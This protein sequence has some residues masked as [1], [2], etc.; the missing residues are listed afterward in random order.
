[1]TDTV[2][3][4]L[5]I[6]L[7]LQ[8]KARGTPCLVQV[9]QCFLAPTLNHRIKNAFDHFP[10]NYFIIES[11]EHLRLIEMK[12]LLNFSSFWKVNLSY[13]LRQCFGVILYS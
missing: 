7:F 6:F 5:H 8:L 12:R 4:C 1:M 13:N 3:S 2:L 10:L 9:S 11:T